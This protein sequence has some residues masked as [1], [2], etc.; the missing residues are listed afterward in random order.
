MTR[1]A[2]PPRTDELE[3]SLI[4]RG[5]GECV[6]V[7]LG[8]NEWCVVDSCI[9][10][11]SRHSAAVQY[12][13]EIGNGALDRVR[14][15]VGTHWHDDHIRG[16]TSVLERAFN[17]RFACSAALR[18]ESFFTLVEVVSSTIQGASGVD[19]FASIFRLLQQRAP[20]GT[21]KKL[22]SPMWSVQGRR[23]LDLHGESRSFPASITALSPSDGTVKLAFAD[24][25]KLVPREGEPQRRITGQGANRTSVVLWVQAG[26]RRALLGA[27]LEH[28][29]Q[30]G[31]GW[32]AVLDSHTDS[33]AATVFKV[34]H[35]GSANADCPEVWTKM[36]SADPIS[37]V[38][39]FNS[40]RGL[41]SRSDLDRLKRRTTNLY[42]TAAGTG[43]PP[44]RG[45]LVDKMMRR[46]ATDRRVADGRPGHVRVRWSLSDVDAS[47]TVE[48][49]DGAYRV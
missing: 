7:H 34:P 36:L 42:C 24:F 22:A 44:Q 33:E 27:D 32:I 49:Y 25:A 28:T 1:Q 8:D 17:A 6:V 3:I 12:L 46:I 45:P 9:P 15:V 21:P 11:G 40:G 43:K 5:R 31:E 30:G 41:P 26:D 19:E 23:L 14:L 39:P 18:E 38:A 48:L 37:M 35:H 29:G 16:L 4:G 47:P 20:V 13:S 10:P 2:K